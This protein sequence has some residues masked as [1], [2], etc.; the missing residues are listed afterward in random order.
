MRMIFD[1]GRPA[2]FR[3]SSNGLVVLGV[4]GDEELVLGQAELLGDQVP[5]ELDRDGP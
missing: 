4:D 3:Q 1:S 2:I 5:G